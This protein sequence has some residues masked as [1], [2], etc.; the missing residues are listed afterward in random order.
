MTGTTPPPDKLNAIDV[1]VQEIC[2]QHQRLETLVQ[3]FRQRIEKLGADHGSG[4]CQKSGGYWRLV[5]FVDS[6]VRL[7]LFLENNFNY[8]ETISVLAVA[9][10]LFELTVW[11]KLL[12]ID[13]RYGLVYYREL[14]KKQLDFYTEF[15]NNA[16]REIS[17]LRETSRTEEVLMKSRLSETMRIADEEVRK[18]ALR[19]LNNEITRQIDQEAARKFS[20]Y[21]EQA[22]VNGYEFQAHLVETKIL[23]EYSNAIA[24]LEQKLKTFDSDTPS[25][26][27][28]L[29]PNRWKWNKQAER[30]G[31]KDE[32]DFIYAYAS[33]LLHATPASLTTN[34]KNL[35]PDEMRVFLK[36]FRVRLLDAVEMAEKL[37]A[38]DSPVIE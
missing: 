5:A 23:P 15:R 32:Y 10:Y 34:Q 9:R 38:V 17:F 29:A 22:Q 8:I 33:R 13:S 7:R 26:I 6:L 37:L 30:V 36:Y 16:T 28:A 31:M 3:Q 25:E 4:P 12:V 27:K 1:L 11:L 21:A 18:T 20:L 19:Q 24:D 14:L 2:G 35:E